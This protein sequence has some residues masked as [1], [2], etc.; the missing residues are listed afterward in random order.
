[1]EK[2][3]QKQLGRK[4]KAIEL[5][6]AALKA[7]FDFAEAN[8]EKQDPFVVE[9]MDKTAGQILI[10][11]NAAAAIGC[12]MA[13]SRSWLVSHH[14][15]VV[16]SEALIE[17]LKT[18]PARPGREGDLRRGPGRGR[19]GGAGHGHRRRLGRRA[20]MTSTAGPAYRSW[21]NSSAWVLR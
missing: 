19:V 13:A 4:L 7:G 17:Y 9:P 14:A 16:V 20:A 15:L 12:M 11:G 3:L 21:R 10:E 8:L 5:N 18:L 2:A 6:M 1:M